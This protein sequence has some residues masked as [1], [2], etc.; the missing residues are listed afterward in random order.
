MKLAMKLL[1]APLVTALVALG[2]G[3]IGTWLMSRETAA[4]EQAFENAFDQY[5]TISTAQEQ[6]ATAHSKVYRTVALIAS[7]D[8][9]K[10]K[11]FLEDLNK[12]LNGVK[13]TVEG[14]L[15][16]TGGDPELAQF[17]QV[18]GKQ[19]DKY[20]KQTSAAIDMA[21]VDANTG[22]ASMQEAD[23]SYG[24]VADTMR[25]IVAR[26]DVLSTE[27]REA[28]SERSH[29]MNIL[30]LLLGICAA[31]GTVFVSYLM[32]RSLVRELD[33]AGKVA[34]EVAGG[35]LVVDFST[36]RADEVG[37]LM[38][39]LGAMTKQ[40]GNS[41][42]VVLASSESIRVAS[43]EIA[44]GN[45]DLSQRTEQAASN[46]Q[47]T[48]SSM[49]QLTGTVS[50]TADSARQADQL[51]AS[52][53]E[54]ASRGG[55]L[56]SQ[57][58]KTMDEIN[59]SSKK[60]GDII[61]VIDGIAFQTN[62]L[63]LNAAVEAARAGEQGRGF[64]VVASEV[65]SLAQRSAQAAREI[66][67]LVGAS[68]ERVENGSRLVAQAGETMTEIVTSVQR[69]SHI[70]GEITSAA[71]AQSQGIGSVNTAVGQL[72]Q[73]TQQNAAL[74][75]Q[76]AAAAESLNDQAGKLAQMVGAFRLTEGAPAEEQQAETAAA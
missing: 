37:D 56:V 29:N 34:G 11:A 47:R 63:A 22:I 19:I 75:E 51:A 41:M 12:Q 71:A 16:T 15:A 73:M 61:G 25:A 38:R 50:Q 72:D 32:Q 6:L 14:T 35:N 2:A 30:L 40:L 70:V 60:I 28:A 44:S 68:V 4:S 49:D 1:A 8:D 67:G 10:L 55:D 53:A 65:R 52:A 3:Q 9:K 58:V 33:R 17:A 23:G 13:R 64:A 46:L 54:V 74:V 57:V 69:V 21:S 39:A 31:A 45:L 5:Q 7:L 24:Q 27:S 62:I 18:I 36:R 59:G 43:S 20:L 42:R 48:A 76:C 66:K 26:I